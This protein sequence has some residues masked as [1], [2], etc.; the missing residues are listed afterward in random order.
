MIVGSVAVVVASTSIVVCL[1]LCP[2]TVSVVSRPSC[3]STSTTLAAV[4]VRVALDGADEVDMRSVDSCSSAAR[5]RTVSVAATQATAASVA[6]PA[7]ACDRS[8]QPAS[9]P[10]AASGSATRH[11]SATPR[12]SS[13]SSSASSASAASSASRAAR[14]LA[15]RERLALQGDEPGGPLALDPRLDKA[16]DRGAD[17]LD[18]L[19]HIRGRARARPRRVVELVRQPGRHLA[20]RGQ[21]LALLLGRGDP[22]GYRRDLAHDAAV[23]RGRG[24][25]EPA[26]VLGRDHRHAALVSARMLTAHGPPVS[27]AI[28]QIHVG[29]NWRPTGSCARPGRA[30]PR[31]CPRAGRSRPAARSPCSAST[32]LARMS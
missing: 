2:S 9:S 30:R 10:A 27:T 26:E 14:E 8:S 6:G 24:Q 11:G 12:S 21:A 7:S 13:R 3:R 23:H 22:A 31:P 20:Q 16:P 5:P 19:G 28:A 29:A 32:L 4:H 18:R 25:R 15:P 17:D 1:S